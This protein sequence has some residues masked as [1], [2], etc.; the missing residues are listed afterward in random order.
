VIQVVGC[1]QLE[2]DV[3]GLGDKVQLY[4]LH[5]GSVLTDMPQ[6]NPTSNRADRKR[7]WHLMFKQHIP[8]WPRQ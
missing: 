2:L 5:P 3:E 8:I 7:Q 6:S 1:I 4:A